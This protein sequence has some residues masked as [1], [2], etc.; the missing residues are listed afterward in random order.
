MSQGGTTVSL[1]ITSS[2]TTGDALN[3][4]SPVDTNNAFITKEEQAFEKDDEE[5]E[6]QEATSQLQRS[7]VT[8]SPHASSNSSSSSSSSSDKMEIETALSTNN[9]N[10]E[11][12][13]NVK[14][15]D[16]QAVSSSPRSEESL[17]T[18]QFSDDEQANQQQHPSS[19]G[20]CLN[21]GVL[22]AAMES[23]D[24]SNAKMQ[25]TH[26]AVTSDDSASEEQNDSCAADH[27]LNNGS[28]SL[29]GN[30][31]SSTTKNEKAD[32][33]PQDDTASDPSLNDETND[34]RPPPA[35]AKLSS[36]TQSNKELSVTQKV[37][38]TAETVSNEEQPTDVTNTH[39]Q[40]GPAT[41]PQK[42]APPVVIDLLDSDDDEEEDAKESSNTSSSQ[43]I[44]QLAI[45][46]HIQD[47][48][49]QKVMAQNSIVTTEAALASH[50]SRAAHMPEWM[51][52]KSLI[53]QPAGMPIQP[54]ISLP[55]LASAKPA[56]LPPPGVAA[57]H[58]PAA[59]AAAAAAAV[60]Q[61]QPETSPQHRQALYKY[62][63]PFFLRNPDGFVPTWE[64][65]LPEYAAVRPQQKRQ[66]RAF[67]L[68]LLNVSEF[69]I[70]GL[71][72]TW[73]G[74]PTPVSGLRKAIKGISRDHGKAVYE[75]NREGGGRW[76]IPLGAYHSFLTFLKSD[77]LT[78]VEGVPQNQLQI[79]SLERARQ[80]KGYPTAEELMEQGLPCGLAKALAPFQRGGVDFVLNKGGRALIADGMYGVIF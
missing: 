66:R 6:K 22:A 56:P 38:E 80:E 42:R 29:Q 5:E 69:T 44:T 55:G 4:R 21:D 7:S 16:D 2:T 75:K 54:G 30:D 41:V 68:S 57:Q 25:H 15:K 32:K 17:A 47:R 52:Q 60:V 45:V 77:P 14:S 61:P 51:K 53:R 72:L 1:E 12:T 19:N 27:Q 9:F 65:L 74:P 58:P 31:A 63:T 36:A 24:E 26:S 73:E 23:K 64:K 37:T 59:A 62:N 10:S 28:N 43:D 39:Q 79:A 20:V 48:K 33:A 18:Q 70:D 76:R 8:P 46:Q 71:P 11:D 35:T 40:N 67:R 78:I 34:N 3:D 13:P 49:R 50:H